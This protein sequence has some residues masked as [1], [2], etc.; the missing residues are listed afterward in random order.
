MRKD[1]RKEKGLEKEDLLWVNQEEGRTSHKDQF[2]F[3]VKASDVKPIGFVFVNSVS[4]FSRFSHFSLLL[5]SLSS[6]H[7]SVWL[8]DIGGVIIRF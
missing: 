3:F 1:S 5:V 4:S 7:A 6:I 8:S 2:D